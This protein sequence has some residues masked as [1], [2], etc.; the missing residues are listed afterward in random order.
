MLMARLTP[1]T[2]LARYQALG[3]G[4]SIVKILA[5]LSAGDRVSVKTLKQWSVK[6][7][8][9]KAT[10]EGDRRV[11]RVAH[12]AVVVTQG[13]EA[14]SAAISMERFTRLAFDRAAELVASAQTIADVA[15]IVEKAIDAQKQ[16]AV[17]AGGVSDRTESVAGAPAAKSA[18]ERD[19]E[20]EAEFGLTTSVPA[21]PSAKPH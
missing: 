8:W 21:S 18:A 4:R 9:G 11:A 20:L 3:E 10:R 19:R 15:V 16:L 5:G 2:A 17:M 7:G 1:A 6:F 13:K 14:A 12:E